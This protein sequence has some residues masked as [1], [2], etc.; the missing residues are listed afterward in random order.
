M[1]QKAGSNLKI[2][3]KINSQYQKVGRSCA[4]FKGCYG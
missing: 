1:Q 4:R 2:K 3:I